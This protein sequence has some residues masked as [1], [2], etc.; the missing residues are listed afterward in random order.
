MRSNY[1]EFLIVSNKEIALQ[2]MQNEIAYYAKYKIKKII[3]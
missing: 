1:A 3:K 2:D